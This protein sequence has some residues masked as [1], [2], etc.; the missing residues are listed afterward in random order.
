[1]ADRVV[2]VDVERRLPYDHVDSKG[3]EWR[4]AIPQADRD[5]L[6]T[7]R[8]LCAEL[9]RQVNETTKRIRTDVDNAKREHATTGRRSDRAWLL[10]AERAGTH[11][12]QR[13]MMLQEVLALVKR[14]TKELNIAESEAKI[15]AASRGEVD[16]AKVRRL[17]HSLGLA[18]GM[19]DESSGDL[20]NDLSND[21]SGPAE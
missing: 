6:G 16:L 2:I 15:R 3:A 7:I 8:E 19:I 17:W 18:L 9:L 12:A 13:S 14:R 20:S 10:N 4:A 1:M 11:Y 5:T 21:L